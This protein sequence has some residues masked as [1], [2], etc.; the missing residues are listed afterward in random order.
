MQLCNIFEGCFSCQ[1]PC[2][3]LVVQRCMKWW[4]FAQFWL[5]VTVKYEAQDYLTL[6][7]MLFLFRYSG[8]LKKEVVGLFWVGES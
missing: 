8:M 2:L 1:D 3:N 7:P 6:K 5:Q 4:L